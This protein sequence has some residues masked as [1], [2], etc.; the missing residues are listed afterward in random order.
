MDKIKET[1]MVLLSDLQAPR[2]RGGRGVLISIGFATTTAPK[3]RVYFDE[4][5]KTKIR[6][7]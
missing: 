2:G 4:I 6:E 3:A 1:E 7:K 5:E